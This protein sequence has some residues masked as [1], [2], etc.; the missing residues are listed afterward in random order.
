VEHAW[1]QS[2]GGASVGTCLHEAEL[3]LVSHS[4]HPPTD[5][6]FLP[7][8]VTGSLRVELL[9]TGLHM[10]RSA[11]SQLTRR[12]TMRDLGLNTEDSDA[13]YVPF[14]VTASVVATA[15]HIGRT[16]RARCRWVHCRSESAEAPLHVACLLARRKCVMRC[17]LAAPGRAASRRIAV[18]IADR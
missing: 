14:D 4:S 17:M 8:L 11:A 10:E 18:R 7:N 1:Y 2:A 15:E 16:M 13:A 5:F 9:V 12:S 3:L 6:D